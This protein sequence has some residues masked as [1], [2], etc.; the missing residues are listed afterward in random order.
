MRFD[1]HYQVFLAN[2]VHSEDLHF[3]VRYRVYCEER[4]FEDS[5]QFP[6]GLE[7]D[8]WD[9]FSFKFIVRCRRSG[10]YVAA[11]RLVRSSCGQLPLH[12]HCRVTPE[13]G[14]QLPEQ[15]FV[16]LS[17][18]CVL[19]SH[20]SN[21]WGMK[22]AIKGAAYEPGIFWGMVRAAFSVSQDE[23][24]GHWY[25]LTSAALARRLQ[26]CMIHTDQV[27]GPCE[28]NGIRHP[29]LVDVERS[30]QRIMTE[31]PR[32]RRFYYDEPFCR[33]L[34]DLDP[35]FEKSLHSPAVQSVAL[36]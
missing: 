17:R 9:P 2:G 21:F 8:R 5:Q 3:A 22:R 7:H 23:K 16:E 30:R 12:S 6:E 32:L 35:R 14:V 25:F 11:M 1:D 13:W 4:G 18:L 27:G 19:S 20:S 28:L 29:Y 10:D 34:G 33:R 31:S 15:G 36:L 24:I 26:Q